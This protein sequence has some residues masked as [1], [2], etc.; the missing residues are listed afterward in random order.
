LKTSQD[1]E[2][3]THVLTF[4]RCSMWLAGR[5][6]LPLGV[7]THTAL[8]DCKLQPSALNPASEILPHMSQ[9]TQPRDIATLPV[10]GLNIH[11]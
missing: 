3:Q 9:P 6:K 11:L 8:S 10:P 4:P 1:R 2:T 5:S 7:I